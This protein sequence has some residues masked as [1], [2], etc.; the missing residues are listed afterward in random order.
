MKKGSNV[1]DLAMKIHKNLA[2]N[3][4]YAIVTREEKSIKVSKNFILQD[5]DIVEIR[6]Y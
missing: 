5:M 2:K 4:R 3:F 1:I 6:A